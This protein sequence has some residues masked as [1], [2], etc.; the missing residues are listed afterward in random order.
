[1]MGRYRVVQREARISRRLRKKGS[2]DEENFDEACAAVL[3]ALNPPVPTSTVRE[4]LSAPEAKDLS[5]TSSPFWLIASAIQ[6]F[7]ASHAELPLPGAVPDMK[8]QSA[9]YIQLQ[10]I[11][12]N[13]A[14]ADFAEVLETVRRLE[15][16]TNRSPKLAIDGKEVENFCKGAAHIHLVRGRPFHVVQPGEVPRFGDRAKAM[17][18]ELMN[19]ESMIKEYIALP[20]LGRFRG[21][22]HNQLQYYWRARPWPSL[23]RRERGHRRRHGEVDRDHSHHP[24]RPDQGSRRAHRRPGVYGHQRR[25][26]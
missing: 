24:R 15:K 8:A 7:Y 11:Y 9:D 20:R 1:M 17:T 12:K 16:A 3:K 2:P 21:D 10:N 23:R 18:F 4:I 14:R 25:Y 13:K 22:T 26:C 6:Q 19:P 5:A